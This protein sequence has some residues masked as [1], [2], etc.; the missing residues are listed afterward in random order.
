MADLTIRDL[1]HRVVLLH[2]ML[3]PDGIG[4]WIRSFAEYARVFAAV[5]E[6]QA[7]EIDRN[8]QLASSAILE[9]TLRYRDDVREKDRIDYNGRELWIVGVKQ[10]ETKYRWLVITAEERQQR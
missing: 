10:R 1:R 9:L 6:L 7:T 3:T 5:R 4:G 8:M 2:E